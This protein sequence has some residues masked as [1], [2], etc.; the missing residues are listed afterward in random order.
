M[1]ETVLWDCRINCIFFP[2]IPLGVPM[3]SVRIFSH[4]LVIQGVALSGPGPFSDI[5]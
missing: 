2:L 4:T 1:K 5:V 3:R